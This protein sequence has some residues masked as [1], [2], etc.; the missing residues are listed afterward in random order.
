MSTLPQASLLTL[1]EYVSTVLDETQRATRETLETPACPP[2]G[3]GNDRET[4]RYTPSSDS[5]TS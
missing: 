4:V 1:A 3:Q 2:S 5:L